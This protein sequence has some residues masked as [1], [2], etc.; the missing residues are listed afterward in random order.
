MRDR[1]PGISSGLTMVVNSRYFALPVGSTR[2][3][4][5]ARGKPRQGITMDQASTQRMR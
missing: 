3:T 2:F 1:C 5:S 4:R